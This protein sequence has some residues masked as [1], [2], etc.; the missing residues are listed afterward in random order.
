MRT[1]QVLWVTMFVFGLGGCDHD[2]SNSD[3]GSA[4]V[5]AVAGGCLRPSAL[6]G[7]RAQP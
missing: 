5:C 7:G 1:Q 3:K 2:K 6:A 4:P